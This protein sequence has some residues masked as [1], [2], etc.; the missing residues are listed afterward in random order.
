[1]A[2]KWMATTD[3]NTD[4]GTEIPNARLVHFMRMYSGTAGKRPRVQSEN[5]L[6]I[7]DPTVSDYSFARTNRSLP[8]TYDFRYQTTQRGAGGSAEGCYSS[9]IT[10]GQPDANLRK[11]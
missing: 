8:D 2:L 5:V 11:W 6:R 1:M 3:Y 7:P 4:G 9:A 10:S